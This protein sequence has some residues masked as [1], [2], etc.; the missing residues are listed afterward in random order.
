MKGIA[1][2]RLGVSAF[3]AAVLIATGPA[4]AQSAADQSAASEGGSSSEVSDGQLD[5]IVVTARFR[6]ERLQDT[7]LA[8]TAVTG[9]ALADRSIGNVQQMG[10]VVPNAFITPGA[11]AV[12]ATP[13]VSLR[14]VFQADFNFAFEP[15]VAIYVDDVY[16]S[17]L[18]GSAMDLMDLER[19][20]VLRGP[21]GTLFGKNTLGGAIRLQSKTPQGDDSGSIEV[22]YGSFNRLDLKGSFDFSIVPDQLFM[23]VSGVSR[24]VDGY[25]KILDYTCDMLQ[26]GTPQLAG[27]GDGYGLSGAAVAAGSAADLAA[28]LPS[29]IVPT[30][31]LATMTNQANNQSCSLGRTGGESLNAGRAM[32]RYLAGD[33]LEI[34]LAVDYTN[35]HRDVNPDTLIQV[36]NPILS[37]RTAPP[38]FFMSVV[39]DQLLADY[40]LVYDDRFVP[41][42]PYTTYASNRDLAT[43]RSQPNTA[44]VESWGVQGKVDYKFN[45]DLKA[46]LILAHRRYNSQFS[47]DSDVSPLGFGLNGND[48]QHRQTTAEFQFLGQAF[49]GK[50]DWT[51]GGFYLDGE[52][53]LGGAID[54]V[55]LHFLQNDTYLD[56][57]R[58]A[59]AHGALHL[60]DAFN[61][62][63]GVRYTN[64]RKTF[65]FDHIGSGFPVLTQSATTERVDWTIS[66][67]YKISPDVLVY[68]SIATGFRPRSINPRPLTPRQF[69]PIPGENLTSYEIGT[70]G[71]Y[72]DHRLRVNLAAFYSDYNSHLRQLNGFECV[73]ANV[74]VVF[75]PANCPAGSAPFTWFFYVGEK[76]KIYGAEA[77]V[78]IEPVRDLLINGTLG[79]NEFESTGTGPAFF[80][81]SNRVQPKLNAS[82]G[83]QYSFPAPG[84]RLT[85]RLD[86]RY[87]SLMTYN[88]APTMPTAPL[89]NVPGRS[90]FDAR[91]TYKLDKWQASLA[92]SNLFDSFHFNNKFTLT[93]F[94][95]S[96]SPARP[97]E[98]LLS[99][100]REF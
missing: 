99:V 62:T 3:A 88:P 75:D 97:R 45:D 100:K 80:D 32:L 54:Y 83:I 57:S 91:L 22:A 30:A 66:M 50:F 79:Y 49:G 94:N 13:T 82:A 60:S 39:R 53:H 15:G 7:P 95:V 74:D 64:N 28:A 23:R 4:Y 70:K 81:P 27:Y 59:F 67:D 73:G 31:D 10:S 40:G 63:G 78:T 90:V 77:E 43:G 17:T 44:S 84:G 19:V 33:K 20:E 37:S 26:R 11:A 41:S 98:F 96:G 6:E 14:G 9:E 87:Q 35:D 18:M 25:Q 51:V 36:I 72:F 61:I 8:I 46:K 92:V 24:R 21:Q 29:V 58:S 38:D 16:H 93:G 56:E 12:G 85:P 52:S 68:G 34:N 76:A 47:H 69:A 55:V 1:Q 86:W 5:E 71:D 42:D 89:F 48:I 65:T 2:L